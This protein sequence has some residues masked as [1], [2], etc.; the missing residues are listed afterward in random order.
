MIGPVSSVSI[1]MVKIKRNLRAMSVSLIIPSKC[2]LIYKMVLMPFIE[3]VDR[4]ES[5]QNIKSGMF[6]MIV[7]FKS[8]HN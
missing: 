7:L 6:K 4:D 5:W 3:H 2:L 8:I 1:S